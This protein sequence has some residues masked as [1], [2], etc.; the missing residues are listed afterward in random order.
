[1][2]NKT[3]HHVVIGADTFEL[4]D[5]AAREEITSLKEDLSESVGDLKSALTNNSINS[6]YGVENIGFYGAFVRGALNQ[7]ALVPAFLYR[8]SSNTLISFSEDTLITIKSGFKVGF[9]K[10]VSDVYSQD[11][12][13]KTG[14]YIAPANTQFKLMIARTFE[15]SQEVAN[16]L[17]F[18]NA[19]IL[20]ST[21]KKALT[22]TALDVDN[23]KTYCTRTINMFD[24]TYIT[25]ATGWTESSGQYSGL[26]HN[27][28]ASFKLG[29]PGVSGFKANT[30][31]TF[32]LE[33]YTDGSAGTT[34]NGLTVYFHYS[35]NTNSGA[36]LTNTTDEYTKLTL[37]STANK[38]VTAVYLTYGSVNN[39]W[40]IKNIQCEI[41]VI[42]TNYVPYYTM[43]DDVA[44]LGLADLSVIMHS[45]IRSISHGGWY[46]A[47]EN[48][49][50]AFCMS[51]KQ[52]FVYAECDVSFTSDGV[53]VLLHDNTIN[54]TARNADGTEISEAINIWDITY[55]ELL[56]YD[57][58]IWKGEQ[59][60]GTKILTL[61]EFVSLCKNIG[62]HP[63]I[64]LKETTVYTKAMYENCVSIV[65]RY[66]MIRNVTWISFSAICLGY[67][68]AID[69]KA[70][71]GYITWNID[72]STISSVEAL[73][74]DHNEVFI[75][76]HSYNSEEIALCYEADVPLEVWTISSV[77][78]ITGMDHYISG[79]TSDTLI[80]AKV[81]YESEMR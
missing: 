45:N 73:K 5:E 26:I 70:R 6:G 42:A 3:M 46:L 71:L 18:V 53:P 41:G 20:D 11:L 55:A 34:G 12:G 65:K 4:I 43:S 81:L 74:T 54:R 78:G 58:G 69:S 79:F 57:F 28:H 36:V 40:H 31:Y 62:L 7:G 23:L 67:V 30:Q 17:E 66:G 25:N 51:R 21:V 33:A 61:A 37:V 10:F 60:A 50:P 44:R 1:M 13:W 80:A 64:E 72:E 49:L 19:V 35:D 24:P 56:Q 59:Y 27:L 75:D 77:N 16:I 47:P 9:H 29:Y 76:S 15:N 52:G 48:T 68:K 22:Q 8:V 39:T 2:A 38:T 32:S 63:Y 14:T